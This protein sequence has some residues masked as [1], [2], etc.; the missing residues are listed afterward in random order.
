MQRVEDELLALI[1]GRVPGD[2]RRP[3]GNHHLPDIAP[4]QYRAVAIGGRHRVV[5]AVV[6]HQRQCRDPGRFALASLIGGWWPRLQ[7]GKITHQPLAD[8]LVMAQYCSFYD[9]DY[10]I[11]VD[12]GG[13]LWCAGPQWIAAH[14]ALD[15]AW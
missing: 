1:G 13:R 8:T 11:E 3:A 2:D 10:G 4:H 9:L 15:P 7:G 14:L 12:P 5:V 6:A